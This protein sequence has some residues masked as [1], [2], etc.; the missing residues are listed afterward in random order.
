MPLYFLMGNITENGQRRLRANPDL[1]VESVRDC[2]CEGAEILTQ[3]AVLG[4]FD[5][6][7]LAEADD[8]DAVARLSL[9]MSYRVGMHI[10]T[11]PAIALGQ[12]TDLGDDDEDLDV[13]YAE[14]SDGEWR[15]P[16][17]GDAE[18]P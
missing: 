11:L 12:L 1:V 8:N 18:Q 14:Q 5:F 6:V 15:L 16:D 2:E 3:Y 4:R 13:A 10:E 17:S 7:M 9:E